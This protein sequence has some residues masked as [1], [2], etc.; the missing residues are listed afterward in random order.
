MSKKAK[1]VKKV[2]KV[3]VPKTIKV[4]NERFKLISK[5]LDKKEAEKKAEWHRYKGKKVRTNGIGIKEKR[6]EPKNTVT[7]TIIILK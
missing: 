6:C 7:N 5:G 1:K 3:E 2:K 4:G